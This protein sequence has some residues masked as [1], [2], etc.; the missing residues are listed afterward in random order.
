MVGINTY[1]P[2]LLINCHNLVLLEKTL[3]SVALINYV[4]N[5]TLPWMGRDSITGYTPTFRQ[6]SISDSF[7]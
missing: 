2:L 4:L 5:S 6:A 1:I 3:V 7:P